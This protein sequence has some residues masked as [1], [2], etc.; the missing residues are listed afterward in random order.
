ML[1]SKR[2]VYPPKLVLVPK[3]QPGVQKDLSTSDLPE[4]VQKLVKEISVKKIIYLVKTKYV[5]ANYVVEM[6]DNVNDTTN[7]YTSYTRYEIF[8]CSEKY[9]I[10]FKTTHFSS[11]IRNGWYR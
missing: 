3:R 11:S 8:Y 7:V 9:L 6:Y 5:P 10:N 1:A 4:E 2:G